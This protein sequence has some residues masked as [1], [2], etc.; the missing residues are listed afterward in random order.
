MERICDIGSADLRQF[1]DIIA[2]LERM[3][4]DADVRTRI[5]GDIVTLVRAD[6][7]VSYVCEQQGR[8]S[9][10]P[11]AHN[12]DPGSLRRYEAW[13]QFRDPISFRLRARRKATLVEDVMPYAE[14]YKTEFYNDFLKREGQH[15]G[16]NLFLFDGNQDLGDFRLWRSP[17]SPDFGQREV[18]LLD[19]IAPHL[20]RA[21]TRRADNCGPLTS[22]EREVAALVARGCRDR[23]IAAVLGISFST[24]RTHINSAM[25]KKG[26]GNR[27]ELAAAVTRHLGAVQ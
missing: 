1:G 25:E 9:V 3:D 13:Y 24:V 23:E 5:F 2:K 12:M 14:L 4:D 19:A 8:R 20:Q 27:A 10:H 21:L 15:H 6:T 16:L 18:M 11:V 7:A 22:R 26:Y 17:G